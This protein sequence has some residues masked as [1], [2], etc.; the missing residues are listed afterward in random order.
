MFGAQLSIM[1]LFDYVNKKSHFFTLSS[2]WLRGCI[3][4]KFGV[5]LGLMKQ[6]N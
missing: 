4:R 3:M 5:P 2:R 1:D 6:A